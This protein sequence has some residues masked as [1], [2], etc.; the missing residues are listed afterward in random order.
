VTWKEG[1]QC[2][3]TTLIRFVHRRLPHPSLMLDIGS[4]EGA[5]ARELRERHHNV[6]TVD[7]DPNVECTLPCDIHDLEL[8]LGSFDLIYDINTLCHVRVPPYNKIKGWL[9]SDGYFF[10]ICPTYMAPDYIS[11]GKEFTRKTSQYEMRQVLEL[12][13]GFVSISERIEPDFRDNMLDSW[14]VE[15]RP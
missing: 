15:A 14:I 9:K 8:P 11:E 6:I 12:V 13:F 7:K 1:R 5:N 10:S 4:G 2:P 3:D